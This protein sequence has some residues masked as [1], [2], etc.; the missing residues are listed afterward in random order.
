MADIENEV[1]EV[2][3]GIVITVSNYVDESELVW[4]RSLENLPVVSIR[5]IYDHC[6]NSRINGE[7][8]QKTMDHRSK[9]KEERNINANNIGTA[10][11]PPQFMVHA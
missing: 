6:K 1:E 8:I 10:L 7:A 3:L 2:L 11:T 9:F 4:G 5:E